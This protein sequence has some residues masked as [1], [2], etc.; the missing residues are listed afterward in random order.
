MTQWADSESRGDYDDVD[1]FNGLNENSDMNA[2]GEKYRDYY[3]N[4]KLSVSVRYFPST[5]KAQKLVSITVTTPGG[6][7]LKFNTIRSNF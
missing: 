7:E 1:D 4:Y 6:K 2:S 3:S 5:S